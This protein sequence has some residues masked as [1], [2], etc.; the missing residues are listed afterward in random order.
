MSAEHYDAREILERYV[1]ALNKPVDGVIRDA[2]ELGHPKDVIR[3][4]LQHCIKTIA[5][6]DQQGFLRDAYVSLGNF[7]VLTDEERK[8]VATLA[9]IGALGSPG[10]GIH[11]EQTKR[12]GEV[13]GH[14]HG[15]IDRLKAE[16][17]ILAQEL[18]CLPPPEAASLPQDGARLSGTPSPIPSAAS[19]AAVT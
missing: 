14:L 4:V 3:F 18:E 2:A 16:V 7:Q 9:E 11:Q 17:A 13:A 6:A 5:D 15:L 10:S 12:I 1:A 19:S 8:A